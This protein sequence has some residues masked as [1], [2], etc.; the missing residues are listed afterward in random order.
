MATRTSKRLDDL[1]Y[2]I[3]L[4]IVE[5]L[6]INESNAGCNKFRATWVLS[7]VSRRLRETTL[8][9]LSREITLEPKGDFE[10]AVARFLPGGKDNYLATSVRSL[11]TW[12]KYPHWSSY[13]PTSWLPNGNFPFTYLTEFDFPYIL[14]DES[15]INALGRCSQ[16]R[17]LT[18]G[19]CQGWPRAMLEQLPSLSEVHLF[20]G[21]CLHGHDL[22]SYPRVLSYSFIT[23]L[24]LHNMPAY[25]VNDCMK[26]C[27]FPNLTVFL[28][29]SL[30]SNPRSLFQ[31][32]H[33]HPTLL[34]VSVDT[35]TSVIRFEA[36]LM[37]IEGTGTWTTTDS[38][39]ETNIHEAKVCTIIYEPPDTVPP[40]LFPVNIVPGV[41]VIC[42]SFSF[43]RSHLQP[44]IP[45]WSSPFASM[46]PLYKCISLAI[47]GLREYPPETVDLDED[48][49]G[50]IKALER[51]SQVAP[52]LEELRLHVEDYTSTSHFMEW[53]ESMVGRILRNLRHLRKLALY[54]YVAKTY[55]F[56]ACWGFQNE[57]GRRGNRYVPYLDDAEPPY[58]VKRFRMKMLTLGELEGSI[59]PFISNRI[60]AGI[61]E[62]LEL[63]DE[64][65]LDSYDD[66]LMIRAWKARNEEYADQV[67]KV[68]AFVCPQ[69]V[70]FDWYF[71][72]EK[73]TPVRGF[74]DPKTVLWSYK[75]LRNRSDPCLVEPLGTLRWTGC[76]LGDPL[77]LYPL[78]GQELKRVRNLGE[79]AWVRNLRS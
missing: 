17:K 11:R 18:V 28:V 32:V 71:L 65:E 19:S 10:V 44:D 31:F 3:L 48:D 77:P 45:R 22:P 2:E 55:R 42:N 20:A 26:S 46:S 53:T 5:F 67:A 21:N 9:L 1:P 57:Y 68:V 72:T 76:L 58:D 74:D 43:V 25:L 40:D 34:E 13:L 6:Y 39:Q 75:F 23:T 33:S 47:G 35:D 78:V 27:R 64:D 15:M 62:A 60:T 52:D 59:G 73:S 4:E 66:T 79:R 70:A 30:L 36:L 12:S 24:S 29:Q 41:Q 7:R 61:R 56:K 8:R 54:W 37:L 49:V 51:L 38:T 14:L 63:A 50:V 69:L 16:L